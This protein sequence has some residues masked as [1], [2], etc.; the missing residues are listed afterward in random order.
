MGEEE[1]A[2]EI[3]THH[4]VVRLSAGCKMAILYLLLSVHVQC[5]IIACMFRQL[6]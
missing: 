5:I 6:P 4:S 1:G 3:G 2:D